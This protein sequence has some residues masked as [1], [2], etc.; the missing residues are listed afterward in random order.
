MER[1]QQTDL[2]E[3]W[4][5]VDFSEDHFD[6]RLAVYQHYYNWDLIPGSLGK[7]SIDRVVEL[8][9]WTLIGDEFEEL[10]NAAKEFLCVCD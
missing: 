5:L 10:Y 1:A 2:K 9:R 7:I 6:D 3:F 4:A 8:S